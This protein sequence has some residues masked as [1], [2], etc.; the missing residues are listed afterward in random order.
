MECL[1]CNKLT[2]NAKYCSKSCA[3]KANNKLF[4]KRKPSRICT[5]CNDVVANY[6]TT[7]CT[8][9]LEEYKGRSLERFKLRTIGEY[10]A[11][12]SIQGKHASW[13]HVH[14][15]HFNRSWNKELRSKPCANCGYSKHVE[16]CHLKPISEFPDSALLS[17]VNDPIN[18]IQLCRN[19]HWELDNNLLIL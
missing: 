13:T 14:I 11:F 4:P 3:A 16:L 2:K 9:H 8:I 5:Q 7:L 17:E 12:L 10:R 1:T 18:I 19:C 15:R 6:R